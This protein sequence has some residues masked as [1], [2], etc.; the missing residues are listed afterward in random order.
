M[1][2]RAPGKVVI[3]GAYSV[4]WGAPAIVTAVDR[5]VEADSERTADFVSHEMRE[6]LVEPYPHFDASDLRANG[7]KLGLGSSAAILAATLGCVGAEDPGLPSTRAPLFEKA[8]LAHR[9]AQGGGS[10]VDVAASTFGG[11]LV[12]QLPEPLAPSAT[13]YALGLLPRVSPATLPAVVIEVWASP[14]A[15]ITADFIRKVCAW[16]LSSPS[17]FGPRLDE[18][19]A[20][21]VAAVAALS[22]A[23]ARGF[24][25]ALDRQS[26][27]LDQLGHDV[28]LPI[29]VDAVRHLAELARQEEATVLPAGAG[30]GDVSLFVGLRPPSDSL[31]AEQRSAGLD[32]L[33]LSVHARGVHR[34]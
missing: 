33:D 23:H 34:V 27:A 9:R 19:S 15:A 4:L 31:R 32:A 18:L 2:A 14:E 28:G 1:K 7:R 21:A 24:I 10:G 25:D 6:A 13:S 5:Y 11:T 3:S 29:C 30:G 8:L 12:V 20:A 26:R 16:A 17:V 22:S